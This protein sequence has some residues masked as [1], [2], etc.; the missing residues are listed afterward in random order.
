MQPSIGTQR[1]EARRSAAASAH[2]CGG[3]E[4]DDTLDYIFRVRNDGVKSVLGLIEAELMGDDLLHVDGAVGD[5]RDSRGVEV[6]V[7]ESDWMVS[8]L[9]MIWAK[10]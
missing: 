6:A 7:A 5:G 4:G 3:S 10:L 8:S 2:S 9:L 1:A